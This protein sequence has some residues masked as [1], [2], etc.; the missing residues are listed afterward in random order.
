[1]ILAGILWHVLSVAQLAAGTPHTHVE[2]GGFV[3][4]VRREEDGDLHIRLCD[5]PRLE[6]MDRRRCVVAECIPALPCEPPMVGDRIRIRGISRWDAE[7][8]HGWREVH[9]VLELREG[10]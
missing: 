10:G 4:Y 1:M 6:R 9:P 8:A 3:T 5:S 7:R 2:V